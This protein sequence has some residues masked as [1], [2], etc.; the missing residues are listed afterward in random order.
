[1]I[2]PG[3][4]ISAVEPNDYTDLARFLAGF[5]SDRLSEEE[6]LARLGYW[7]EDNPAFTNGWTRGF[8]LVASGSI[9]GFVG[10]FPTLLK[11][12][13]QDTVVFNGTTW[14][15]SERYRNESIDLWLYNRKISKDYIS[16]NTTPT[17]QVA[18]L[19]T[20]YNYQLYPWG[21]NRQF[22][23]LLKPSLIVNAKFKLLPGVIAELAGAIIKMVQK[24]KCRLANSELK[25]V[26]ITEVADSCDELWDKNKNYF[27]VTNVRNSLSVAWYARG[28][29][30]IKLM[31]NNTMVGYAIFYISVQPDTGFNELVLSDLFLDHAISADKAIK[32]IIRDLGRVVAQK[33]FVIMKFPCFSS[34]L[35]ETYSN[36]KLSSKEVKLSG[37]V[38]VPDGHPQILLSE[39]P[40][41]VQLQGDWGSFGASI[42][43][44]LP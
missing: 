42:P 31:L 3:T 30:L 11:I 29:L 19:I 14:R 40:Y 44:E 9:V 4:E 26:I 12:G 27:D 20:K 17:E 22:Y 39:K 28:K 21:I 37:Y 24:A 8:K 25:A 1:M 2:I 10:S 7:W 5:P 43:V 23:Y 41:F 38:R 33:Q 18:N 13:D 35:T 32:A 15:V 36:I 34:Q 6:W 16:F